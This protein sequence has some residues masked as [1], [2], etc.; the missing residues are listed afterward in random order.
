MPV[1]I[2]CK[3]SKCYFKIIRKNTQR[4]TKKDSETRCF[5]PTVRCP[6]V[7][8]AL[9]WVSKTTHCLNSKHKSPAL[10]QFA[11]IPTVWLGTHLPTEALT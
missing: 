6:P 1:F 10:V 5:Q 8:G 4:Q 9:W 2:H 11:Q 7:G 3:L